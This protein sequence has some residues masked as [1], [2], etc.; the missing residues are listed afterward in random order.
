MLLKLSDTNKPDT[1]LKI[2]A[3]LANNIKLLQKNM[4]K[5]DN[6]LPF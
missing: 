5:N 3:E 4:P 2:L 1:K 6:N